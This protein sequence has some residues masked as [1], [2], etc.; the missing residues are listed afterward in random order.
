MLTP[1]ATVRFQGIVPDPWN[2][3]EVGQ[4][5]IEVRV[6]AIRASGVLLTGDQRAADSGPAV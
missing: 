5:A 6:S 3:W 1:D 2:C 4:C